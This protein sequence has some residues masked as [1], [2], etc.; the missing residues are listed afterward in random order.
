LAFHRYP[1]P[2]GADT[3]GSWA[4]RVL[5][6]TCCRPAPGHTGPG[7]GDASQLM[8]GRCAAGEPGITGAP[9][10]AGCGPPFGTA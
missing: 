9:K 6:L 2:C 3:G 5:G 8:A 7:H 1:R 10:H 4:L